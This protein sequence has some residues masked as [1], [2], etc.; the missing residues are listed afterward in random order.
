[1]AARGTAEDAARVNDQ[2]GHLEH[3]ADRISS[4]VTLGEH[5]A[6]S[7][8]DVTREILAQLGG[9]PGDG[10]A[11]SLRG[12]HSDAGPMHRPARNPR[13]TDDAGPLGA[14]GP[15]LSD[16]GK[17]AAVG[18]EPL[19]F[20]FRGQ[21]SARVSTPPI[22]GRCHE[23]AV[24]Y[25]HSWRWT[26]KYLVTGA[27]TL[28]LITAGCQPPG[29]TA[30]KEDVEKITEQLAKLQSDLTELKDRIPAR[31]QQPP[32]EDPNTVYDIPVGSSPVMGNPDA[33][34]AMV[35]F[36]DFQCP[37]CARVQPT[38]KAMLEKYPDKLKLVYKHFPLSFHREARP[39]AIATMAAQEQGKF[40]EMH[41]KLFEN[42]RALAPA[43]FEKYAEEIGLDVAKF[44]ADYESK[45]AEYDKR[46][47]ADMQLGQKS[48]VRGTPSLYIG[49][50]KVT[51]RS[52]AGMSRLV[53]EALEREG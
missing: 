41:D 46:V 31:R 25:A 18:P 35:E 21:Y 6:R 38:L 12:L 44:K 43:N 33:P 30:S 16:A 2:L 9:R 5:R 52:I 36:S 13:G 26:M 39:A 49:G 29:D 42:Q 7:V 24:N 45:Q 10:A 22:D 20:R 47:T 32:A 8:A 53:E 17:P 51:D 37:F 34:V 28:A 11:L 19:E 50:K 15:A 4:Q 40:W 27:L 23:K 14:G 1:M 3:S 48:A